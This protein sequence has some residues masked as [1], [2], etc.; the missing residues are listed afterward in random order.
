MAAN[1][2]VTKEE[3]VGMLVDAGQM[4]RLVGDPTGLVAAARELGKM[5]GFYA[6]EVKKTL[7]G[8]DK[9]TLKKALEELSDEEL[10]KLAHA[11]VIDGESVRVLDDKTVL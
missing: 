9:G 6:P 3:V 8:L 2:G 11:K 1:T 4:A 5:L 7:H 10:H